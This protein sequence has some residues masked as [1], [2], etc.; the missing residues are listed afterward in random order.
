MSKKKRQLSTELLRWLLPVLIL[1]AAASVLL[2]FYPSRDG[3][4]LNTISREVPERPPSLEFRQQGE[5]TFVS[6]AGDSITT[7]AIEIA[8]DNGKRQ[9][10]LM[11]RTGLAENQ[12][13]LFVFLQEDYRS[14]WMKNTILS[15]D[16][17]FVNSN[18]KIVTIQKN[19]IPFSEA[20][21]PSN[22][23]ALYVVEVNAGF[24]DRYGIKVGDKIN[25]QRY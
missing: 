24:T 3:A 6:A 13:M 16:M 10:G 21:V 2:W 11:Y 15:L 18:L 9:L 19:T 25:W 1:V 7:I 23:P 20:G 8:D 14:F 4:H 5:L 12:G 17:V 22:R